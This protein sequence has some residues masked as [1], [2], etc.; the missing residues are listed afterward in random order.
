MTDET[1]RKVIAEVLRRAKQV[2]DQADEELISP[3]DID[4]ITAPLREGERRLM[5]KKIEPFQAVLVEPPEESKKLHGWVEDLHP[6]Y[7]G[8]TGVV[9]NIIPAANKPGAW[10]F[11]AWFRDASL[12]GPPEWFAPGE[13]PVGNGEEV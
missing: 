4:Y 12:S 2:K 7:V 13:A 3:W 11:E 8:E 5:T 9:I 1:T 6:R 10:V